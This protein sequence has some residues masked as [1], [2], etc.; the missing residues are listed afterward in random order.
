MQSLFEEADAQFMAFGEGCAV[1]AMHDVLEMEYAPI[2]KA[3][4]LM[5][6]PHRALIELT[7]A[8][9]LDFLHRLTTNDMNAMKQG[10]VRR[11]ML[12]GAKGRIQSDM[13]VAQDHE[14]TLIDVD[15]ISAQT[16][17]DELDAMLF[18]EDVQIVD[19][20]E[21]YH[22]VS[23]HGPNALNVLARFGDKGFDPTVP[24]EYQELQLGMILTDVLR[25]DEC[26]A[27]GYHL[28][29][30]REHAPVL[31]RALVEAGEGEGIYPLGW[32]AYNIARIEAGVPLFMID[33]G[34]DTLPG[35]TGQLD[36]AVS[37]TKG[38]YRGQEVVA[39]MRDIGHPS[40]LLVGFDVVESD[41]LPVAGTPIYD[42]PRGKAVGAVTS[43]TPSP[44][45]GGK[46]IG[47]AMVKW[48]L[49]DAGTRLSAP[50]EGEHVEIEITDL[51][52]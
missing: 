34:T 36:E 26:G 15:A 39:R 42:E 52:R 14:K 45:R 35:E 9:R 4:G 16:V 8:D 31:W 38:C 3:V 21:T 22:R 24:F 44:M 46:P 23:L 25:W 19:R 27:R 40:K 18:G 2:R 33:Y 37:F 5:D 41:R 30:I 49:R 50:A 6:C 43:S 11:T 17:L 29:T 7:G 12:L 28:W 32:L 48:D 20:R 51:S 10:E 1:V 13:L 47:I